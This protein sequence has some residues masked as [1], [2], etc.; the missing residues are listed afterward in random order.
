MDQTP[1]LYHYELS[2]F[3][4]KVR[5]FLGY[6]GVAWQSVVVSPSPPRD[7]LMALSG[8]YRRI[9]VL[10][11][12]ADIYCDSRL[13]TH[14][15]ASLVGKQDE[16]FPAHKPAV[17]VRADWADSRL[18]QVAITASMSTNAFKNMAPYMTKKEALQLTVDRLG[19]ARHANMP[20]IGPKQARREFLDFLQLFDKQLG[21]DFS[22]GRQ[23]TIA[24]FSTYH[25][26]HFSQVRCGAG[27]LDRY[28]RILDWLQ[29]M[30]DIG[31]GRHKEI[32]SE[33]ATSIA[34]ENKPAAIPDNDNVEPRLVRI[35]PYDYALNPVAGEL[36]GENSRSWTLKRTVS[37]EVGEVN[38]HLP[39]LG[40][41]ITDV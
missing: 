1:I 18:F 9:P 11:I 36:V 22:F 20:R 3:S 27:H 26:L 14:H 10:Q 6:C 31:H 40:F 33:S 5:S 4:E 17:Q 16:L 41:S 2:P 12:G 7:A 19:M 13:I 15:I 30:Q 39:K 32:S 25:V 8:G 35:Q 34:A 37:E 23:P 38:V 29:R 24:D 28:P 21:N